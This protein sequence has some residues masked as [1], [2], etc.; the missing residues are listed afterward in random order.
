MWDDIKIV[1]IEVVLNNIKDI[2]PPSLPPSVPLFRWENLI[3]HWVS[4]KLQ[5]WPFYQYLFLLLLS[6]S[7]VSARCF[8][9]TPLPLNSPKT[10]RFSHFLIH[11]ALLWYFIIQKKYV[12]SPHR[13]PPL[14]TWNVCSG[15]ILSWSFVQGM[16]VS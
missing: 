10:P 8:M 12:Q 14:L 1:L 6:T 5:S 3:E 13:P 7:C 11:I 16:Y 4:S 15:F 2:F 9:T